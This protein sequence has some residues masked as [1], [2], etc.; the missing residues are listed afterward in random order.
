MIRAR[1]LYARGRLAEALA[2][3]DRVDSASTRR[4]EADQLRIE[5]QNLLLATRP[6]TVPSPAA[7]ATTAGRP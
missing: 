5:I 1:T 4:V 6:S 3:L 7:R 2:V